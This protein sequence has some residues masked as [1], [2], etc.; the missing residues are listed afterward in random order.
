MLLDYLPTHPWT[1]ARARTHTL[2]AG[3]G[4]MGKNYRNTS[5]VSKTPRRPFEKERLNAEMKLLGEYGL[6]CKREVWRVQ[7]TL[8]K[9]RAIARTLLTL[10]EKD[11]KRSPH[12]H[13]RITPAP[14]L[15]PPPYPLTHSHHF[16]AH[17]AHQT[18]TLPPHT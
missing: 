12:H 7:Y 13:T 1:Y 10:P 18:T 11:P 9:C 4:D 5:K 3:L 16:S 2:L 17:N 15:H 6:R 14:T 8:A